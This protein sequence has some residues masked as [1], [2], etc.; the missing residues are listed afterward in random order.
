MGKIKANDIIET[1]DKL[2]T[3]I[4]KYWNIIRIENVV[5]KNYQR[6]Y[7]LKA[8]HTLIQDLA[9]K[10]ADAKL[11]ALCL[12]LGIDSYDKLSNDCNQM[13]IFMLCELQEQKVQLNQIKTINP[14]LKA[15]K[16]K[17]N[18]NKTEV[19]TSNYI[20]AHIDELD[21]RI[22]EYKKKIADFNE[23]HTFDDTV[24]Y[25]GFTA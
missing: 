15:L 14:K 13:N 18:L 21:K 11:K 3:E 7:D 24:I 10:R 6:N 5:N 4:T 16:G 19:M 12:N 20:K 17:K 9:I 8:L 22:I 2:S 23:S 25:K 1:R